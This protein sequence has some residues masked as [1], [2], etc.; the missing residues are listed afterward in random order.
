MKLSS[1][2]RFC[3]NVSQLVLASSVKSFNNLG[4]DLSSNIMAI[5]LYVLGSFMKDRIRSNMHGSL[6]VTIKRYWLT[7]W[8][9]QVRFD[10]TQG[11]LS[12]ETISEAPLIVILYQL[13]K[14]W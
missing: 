4:L 11:R 13:L 12:G 7:S 1:G 8:G 6:I 2:K 3:E 5:S 10:Y 14:L 9:S